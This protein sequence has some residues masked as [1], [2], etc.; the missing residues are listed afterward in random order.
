MAM[1]KTTVYLSAALKAELDRATLDAGRSAAEI[2]R[3]GISLAVAQRMPAPTMPILVS[4][5]PYFAEQV[6]E[7]LAGFGEP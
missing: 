3:E 6:D 5:D 4:A 7:R 2:I 1:E